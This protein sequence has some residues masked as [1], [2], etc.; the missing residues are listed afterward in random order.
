MS[1]EERTGWRDEALSRRHRLW[2]FNCPMVD[3]DFLVVEFD[4]ARV[5][6]LVEYKNGFAPPQYA[7]H[8]NYRAL[9]DLADRAKVALFACRYSSDFQTFRAVPLNAQAKRHLP[10]AQ[11]LDERAWVALLYA[12]RGRP[13]P[14]DLF[15]QR[16]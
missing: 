14:A 1:S 4:Q 7:S 13:M 6:A 10:Q 12:V 8:P 3:I 9:A 5:C 2:G 15:D 11:D 16:I